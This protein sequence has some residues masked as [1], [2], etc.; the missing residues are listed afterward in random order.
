MKRNLF[1][2]FIVRSGTGR[3]FNIMDVSPTDEEAE[4][5]KRLA[6]VKGHYLAGGNSPEV[7]NELRSLILYFIGINRIDK[8]QGL[9]TLQ[10][11]V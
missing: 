3:Q 7:I 11:I 5:E 6:I 8:K 4:K 9:A 1:E 10:S 2:N